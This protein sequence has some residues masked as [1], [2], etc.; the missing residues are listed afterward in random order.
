MRVFQPLDNSGAEHLVSVVP[1]RKLARGY[2]ALRSVE[3]DEEAVFTH[4]EGGILKRLA[5]ADADAVAAHFARQHGKIR[6]DPMDFIR[7]N[8]KTAA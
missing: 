6:T 3:E 8:A 5:I 7:S 1:D 2:A 4:D